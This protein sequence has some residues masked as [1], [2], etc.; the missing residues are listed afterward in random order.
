[1]VICLCVSGCS[2]PSD[3][4]GY[5]AV[6]KMV[7]VLECIPVSIHA[8]TRFYYMCAFVWP[9]VIVVFMSTHFTMVS[10]YLFKG[11]NHASQDLAHSNTWNPSANFPCPF[12]GAYDRCISALFNSNEVLNLAIFYTI[13]YTITT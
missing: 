12:S 8:L 13:P 9:L 6:K 2:S 11:C 7:G 5:W 3:Q 4:L 1:M 10:S